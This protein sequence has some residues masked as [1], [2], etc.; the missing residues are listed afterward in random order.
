M[1]SYKTFLRNVTS[2]EEKKVLETVYSIT[3]KRPMDFCLLELFK[4]KFTCYYAHRKP[5][6]LFAIYSMKKKKNIGIFTHYCSNYFS[7]ITCGILN[8]FIC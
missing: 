8:Q 5:G 2:K 3:F 7:I 1:K 6:L 4:R